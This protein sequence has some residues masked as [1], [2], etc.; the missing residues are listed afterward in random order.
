MPKI[1]I[2]QT[3]PPTITPYDGAKILRTDQTT[4]YFTGDDGDVE[5]G[6]GDSWLALTYNNPFGHKRRFS[7][8]TGG[9]HNGSGFVD[10]DGVATTE[11]LAFP[12]GWAIDWMTFDRDNESYAMYQRTPRASS[13]SYTTVLGEQP[14]TIGG[15]NDVRYCNI[16]E[17]IQISR[18]GVM[19][20]TAILNYQPFNYSIT[21][22]NATRVGSITNDGTNKQII[23][24]VGGVTTLS[25]GTGTVYWYIRWGTLTEIGL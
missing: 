21:G 12:D 9:Y 20:G 25:V 11:A 8:I 6:R 23:N 4:S 17:L 24:N 19:L 1:I 5:R 18:M 7:G 16:N 10:V 22:T 3:S 15:Y 13:T 2:K 14:V